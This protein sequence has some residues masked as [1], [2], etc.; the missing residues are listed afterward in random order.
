MTSW[1][2]GF[3]QLADAFARGFPG[4]LDRIQQLLEALAADPTCVEL[5]LEMRREFHNISGTSGS[6]GFD[7]ISR[8]GHQGEVLS[9]ETVSSIDA[10]TMESLAGTL[11]E[12]RRAAP[13]ERHDSS[14]PAAA[15]SERRERAI[16]V[17]RESILAVE[18]DPEQALLLQRTLESSGYQVRLCTNPKTFRS[19]VSAFR[20]DLVLLDVVLPGTTGFVLARTLRQDQLY[21]AI[22]IIF[23]SAATDEAS[24]EES[25]RSGGDAFLA[26]PVRPKN[27]LAKVAANLEQTN[28]SLAA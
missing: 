16:G 27:L 8:L 18:D 24:Q 12:L 17:T 28:R 1:E 23:L 2:E 11:E 20:P 14:P 6:Y 3:R 13:A 15:E 5:R 19:D 7:E 21:S 25:L 9:I 4:R 10:A 22:P 26:K